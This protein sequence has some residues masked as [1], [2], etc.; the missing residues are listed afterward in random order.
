M[1]GK[2]KSNKKLNIPKGKLSHHVLG[3]LK[4]EE[5]PDLTIPPD[6]KVEHIAIALPVEPDPADPEGK[7]VWERVKEAMGW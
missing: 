4:P 6:I 5:P 3:K 2:R 7:S 1:T